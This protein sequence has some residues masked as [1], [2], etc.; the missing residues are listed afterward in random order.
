MSELPTPKRERWQPL[1]G[2]LMDLYYYEDQQ[3]RYEDGRLLL[4]G[5]NGTGKSRVLALQLPFLLDGEINP[6]RVEP[7][8]DQSKRI[9][10]HLLLNGRYDDRIGYTWIELGRLTED[11]PV[12]CTMGCGMHAHRGRSAPKRWF[13]VTE[14]RIGVDLWLRSDK[15]TALNQSRLRE[16]LGDEVYEKADAYRA[17]VDQKLFGLGPQR[18][19]ALVE[20][21]I[22]L[23]RP[24]LSRKLDE[25]LLSNALSEALPPPSPGILDSVAEAFRGLEG[26]RDQLEGYR[27]ALVATERFAESYRRYVQVALRRGAAEVRRENASY[28]GA[29]RKLK[30]QREIFDRATEEL[31]ALE[32]QQGDKQSELSA[33]QAEVN[34]LLG[35]PAMK[36]ASRLDRAKE[37]ER[38][39]EGRLR[40]AEETVA[41]IV[42]DL[43][44]RKR[45]L[46]EASQVRDR[47]AAAA[48]DARS[49]CLDRVRGTALPELEPLVVADEPDGD[50]IE[51]ALSDRRRQVDHLGR[52]RDALER[53]RS[54][55]RDAERDRNRC[56]EDLE[57]ARDEEAEAA[58]SR[59]AARDSLCAQVDAW[60]RRL[61]IFEGIDADALIEAVREWA[62]TASGRGPVSAAAD[63]AHRLAMDGLSAEGA[64]L[65]AE[66][67]RVRDELAALEEERSRLEGGHHEP[68]ARPA[69]RDP[70]VRASQQGAP[71]WALCDFR[72]G[73]PEDARARLEAALEASGLLDA[74]V[75]PDGRLLADGVYD[76]AAT[77][78]DAVEGSS[79][80]DVLEHAVD[81]EDARAAAVDPDVVTRILR[82]IGSE[83]SARGPWVA[84]DGRFSLGPLAGAAHKDTA[85]HVGQGA[86]EQAR[87]RRIAELSREIER[88]GTVLSQCE[89]ALGEHR[90]RRD[91]ADHERASAPSEEA[92]RDA[93]GRLAQAQRLTAKRHEAFTAAE[94]E[95]ARRAQAAEEAAAELAADAEELGLAVWADRLQELANA[96]TGIE[97]AFRELASR[98]DASRDASRH[99]A[100]MQHVWDTVSAA[101]E[102][103]K[104]QRAARESEHVAQ[105]VERETLES[106]VGAKV[107]EIQ[108]RLDEARRRV[109]AAD[110]ALE[111]LRARESEQREARS[112]AEGRAEELESTVFEADQRRA[113][114]ATAL[115]RVAGTGLFPEAHPEL[116]DIDAEE[117]WSANRA[118]EIARRIDKLLSHVGMGDDE[119]ERINSALHGQLTELQRSLLGHD[120]SP[121]ATEQAD[122]TVVTIPF[123][124]TPMHPTELR[125]ELAGEIDSRE[126]I[127]GEKEREVLEN[128]LIGDVA[129]HLVEL[130]RNGE[131]LVKR[132]N[133]EIIRRPTSTGMRFRFRWEPL[134][135]DDT[136]AAVRKKLMSAHAMWSPEE[137]DA[138]GRFLQDR[139]REERE[140]AETGTW[141][142]H[143]EAALDY[144]KWHQFAVE[145]E[146]N[147]SWQRLTRRTYGTGSGGEKAIALTLPLVAAAAAHYDGAEDHAPRLILFDEAFVGIDSDMRSKCMELLAA[148]DLDFVM[149]SEREWGCYATLPSLAIY[150]L[151]TRPGIPAVHATRW[152]WNG[153]ERSRD[154]SPDEL[155]HEYA[156]E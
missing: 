61:E 93:T 140:R 3:F 80:A 2:G 69:L 142:D 57:A 130:V 4:R 66:R 82:G 128:A 9:E 51:R 8:G 143:L 55:L 116:G 63:E 21:L 106:T 124:G 74:W 100:R 15:G 102:D 123:R 59:D 139:I 73:T 118:V 120:F 78:T 6:A 45:D 17:A 85:E 135:G 36:D 14:R 77:I 83:P 53:R 37:E 46:R 127:L 7:D 43:D 54:D 18:Y 146:Q 145:R 137:R 40:E 114:A 76:T 16:Q 81:P 12:Y 87:R 129:A 107:Q 134:P 19:A 75:T 152:V 125:D 153:R 31:R 68:P 34:T 112:K 48:S 84:V 151:A 121:Q 86:R 104:G 132:M 72:E 113:V 115:R 29:N 52:L 56:S 42:R 60:V 38:S 131:S 30:A 49:T 149:T 91:R 122:L 99:L 1:R 27:Q 67:D 70:E 22:Q 101:L 20:L 26:E 111:S 89:E 88:V 58:S 136:L 109:K 117:E 39:A 95:L 28:E 105:R 98:L 154:D 138:I 32:A 147:G 47:A 103:A 119:R 156:A 108:T 13:F 11:G 155:A 148:F 150:Q 23:R 71:L 5:N 90:A 133:D 50:A 126:R 79:L 33:A 24:Q 97:H 96:L 144:R 64:R 92:L 65:T 141:R 41:R 62:E 44:R 110:E 10:W 94:R 35:D 25:T